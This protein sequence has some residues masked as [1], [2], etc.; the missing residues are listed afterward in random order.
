[1]SLPEE[2]AKSLQRMSPPYWKAGDVTAHGNGNAG[3]VIKG[4]E[5]EKLA[6]LVIDVTPKGESHD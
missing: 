2:M 4:R 3:F 6:I 1:M 5:G